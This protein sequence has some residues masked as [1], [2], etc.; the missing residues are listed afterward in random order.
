MHG[1]CPVERWWSIREY[2]PLRKRKPAWQWLWGM[3]SLMPSHGTGMKRMSQGLLVQ[4]GGLALSAA[5]ASKPDTTRQL[6]MTAFGVGSS[7]GI[8]LPYS[9]LHES[10]ADQLGLV[11]M[12]MAGYDPHEAVDFWERMAQQKKGQAPPEF[13]STHPSDRTRIDNI[14]EQIPEAMKYYKK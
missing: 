2:S 11:F 12:A 6:W 1:V 13:L 5:L 9:R 8:M 4:T 7:V 14:R 3:K 10:E